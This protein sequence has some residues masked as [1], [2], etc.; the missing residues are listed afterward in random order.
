MGLHNLWGPGQCGDV[1]F[2]VQK[3]LRILRHGLRWSH[4]CRSHS[5]EAVSAPSSPLFQTHTWDISELEYGLERGKRDVSPVCPI[6]NLFTPSPSYWEKDGP[7]KIPRRLHL[8]TEFCRGPEVCL[9]PH[10]STEG[11]NPLVADLI[12]LRCAYR[13]LKRKSSAPC[14]T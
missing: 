10:E 8:V 1:R 2:H 9:L 6:C 5:P 4:Q 12:H 7:G 14:V 11:G 13:R 3:S